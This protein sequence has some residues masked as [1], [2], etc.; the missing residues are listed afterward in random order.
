MRGPVRI[1][2][3]PTRATAWRNP[4]FWRSKSALTERI[5]RRPRWRRTCQLRLLADGGLGAPGAAAV[6][7]NAPTAPACG[8]A[9]CSNATPAF[10]RCTGSRAGWPTR[11]CPSRPARWPTAWIGS[12]RC[13]KPLAAA[14]LAHQ[15][16]S[17]VRHGDETGWRIQELRQTGRSG[18]AW[19]WTS[20]QRGRALLPCGPLARAPR[21]PGHC[22]AP[23]KATVFLVCDRFVAYK[24]LARE[25]DGKLVLCFCW[26]HQRRD[27]I[28][29]AARSAETDP[30]VPAM[31]R[32]HRVDLPAERG[33]AGSLR[34]R[35]ATPIA[36]VRRRAA[37]AERGTEG[38]VRG[39]RTGVG[40]P[41]GPTP[42]RPSRCARC[43]ATA[44]G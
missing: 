33:P 5:I 15:N 31:D 12:R 42:A 40:R 20:G 17:P 2:G 16:E 9:C 36:V 18:R 30:M 39:G 3:N 22:S 29:C 21:W 35:P 32:T 24:C 41:G 13:S 28:E 6:R 38:P 4:A 34:S 43:C 23:P 26:V 7:P 19:L 37:R 8:R 44:R 1:A 25:L 10:G 11:A 27:F 14:I